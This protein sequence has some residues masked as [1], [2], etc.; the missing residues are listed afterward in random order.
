M[1]G[2]SLSVRIAISFQR[3]DALAFPAGS[4]LNY[5]IVCVIGAAVRSIYEMLLAGP[6]GAKPRA[7]NSD[8]GRGVAPLAGSTL[9]YIKVPRN[10]E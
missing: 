8:V 4:R 2:R 9:R 1:L 7:D 5:G 3:P 10:P 6:H